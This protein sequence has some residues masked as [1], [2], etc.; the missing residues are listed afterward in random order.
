MR[1]GARRAGGGVGVSG[2]DGGG[3]QEAG[4]RRA[5]A[6]IIRS[7]R[8]PKSKLPESTCFGMRSSVTRLLPEL[9]LIAASAAS[10]E[11]PAL[12]SRVSASVA[13]A[14]FAASSML[15]TALTAWPE[16]GGPMWWTASASQKSATI[17]IAR[18]SAASEPPTMP[19][20]RAAA[21]P[22]GPPAT[23]KSR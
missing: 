20:S 18:R 11:T 19:L 21:A 14:M 23:P 15:L 2:A 7:R 8:K 12:R 3:V 13:V 4:E 22:D 16:P 6:F 5:R 1:E 17:G 10:D 9:E